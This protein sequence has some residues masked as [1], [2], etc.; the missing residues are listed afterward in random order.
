MEYLSHF[1]NELCTFLVLYSI[2]FKSLAA[3][4]FECNYQGNIGP[5]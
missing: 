2:D 1:L 3:Q 5:N 4:S